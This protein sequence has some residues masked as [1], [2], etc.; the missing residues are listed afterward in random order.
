MVL[1]GETEV[2]GEKLSVAVTK[3]NR[4]FLQCDI[5]CFL[6]VIPN[7]NTICG[8]NALLF[9]GKPAGGT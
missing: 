5:R 3:M 1:T 8:Q 6:Q 9:N 7:I 4:C 2:L